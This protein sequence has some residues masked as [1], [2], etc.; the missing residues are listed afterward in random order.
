MTEGTRKHLKET[1]KNGGIAV[2]IL[3]ASLSFGKDLFMDAKDD[4]ENR[5]RGCETQIREIQ[6][7]VAELKINYANLKD[8]LQE[9]K[10]DLKEIKILLQKR[11]P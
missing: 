10:A 5:L 6:L 4:Y 11:V 7:D 1:A 2:A 8:D 9:M 3:L